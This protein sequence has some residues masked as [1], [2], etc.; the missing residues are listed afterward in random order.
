MLRKHAAN[1]E[2]ILSALAWDVK[3]MLQTL[4]MFGHLCTLGSMLWCGV[5]VVL[6]VS[7]GH[8]DTVEDGS[9]D[10][11]ELEAHGKGHRA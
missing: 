9:E 3:T 4:V 11:E 5:D 8:L 7:C 6:T 1:A 2:P 10:Q